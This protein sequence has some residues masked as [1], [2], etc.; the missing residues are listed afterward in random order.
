MDALPLTEATGAEYSSCNKGIMHACGHDAHMAMLLGAAEILN[1]M[2]SEFAGTV[3]LVFQPGEEKAPG[4]AKLMLETGIFDSFNPDIFIAQHLLPDL[5]SATVGFHAGPYMASCDEIYIT[6]T[7]KG[8]HAAQPSQYTDQIYIA[9][10][11]VISTE[12]YCCRKRARR[13]ADRA[14]HRQDNRHGRYK[15]HT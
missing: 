4:G 7:G 14:G 3:L 15:R 5:P 6:V 1:S 12:G 11:L 9:S 13:G 8:G 10:E 2:R